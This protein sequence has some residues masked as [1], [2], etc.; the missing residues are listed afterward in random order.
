MLSGGERNVYLALY[1]NRGG[2]HI[3]EICRLTG[4]SLPAVIK[5]IN[6]GEKEGKVII[7]R[8]GQ[9]KICKLNF[10]S[11]G[12]VPIIQDIELSR[13]QKL[14]H[15]IRESV[16]SFVD[17]L[18]EKPLIILIFGS[19]AKGTYNK[20]SDLD[21]LLVFQRLDDEL[22]KHVETSAT[23]IK[24]RTGVNIQPVSIDYNEFEK[25]M[26]DRKNEFMK[27][28]KKYALV[29][30]GLVLYVKVMEGRLE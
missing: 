16:G 26:L 15:A 14:P 19:F 21:V 9:L 8:K 3:R 6:R 29:L 24:G 22:V 17:D 20:K 4:L 28:I 5:H 25:E 11:K 23:R 27:D 18:K 12:I 13:F 2:M 7:E 30:C 1:L 10:R